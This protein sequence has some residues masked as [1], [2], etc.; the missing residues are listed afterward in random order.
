MWPTARIPENIEYQRSLIFEFACPAISLSQLFFTFPSFL[1][2]GALFGRF[3][4]GHGPS[5]GTALQ[6][7]TKMEA[8]SSRSRVRPI[9]VDFL[10]TL[11]VTFCIGV[12]AALVLGACVM[13]MAGEARGAESGELAPMKTD[14]L[15]EAAPAVDTRAKATELALTHRLVTKYTGLIAIE[16]T[17]AGA[18]ETDFRT[19]AQPAQQLS[20]GQSCE[21]RCGMRNLE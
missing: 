21:A 7:G 9:V 14:A 19:R 5:A 4:T 20:E 16:R 11:F 17:P 13:L 3:N 2:A 6:R 15:R 12:A 1:P 10:G 18:A 8:S